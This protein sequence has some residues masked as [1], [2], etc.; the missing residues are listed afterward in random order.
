MA[1]RIG[2]KTRL[3]PYPD[4]Y[5]EAE[6]AVSTAQDEILIVSNWTLPYR[7]KPEME[8]ARKKYFAAALKKATSTRVKYLRVAQIPPESS[9]ILGAIPPLVVPHLT[10]CMKKRDAGKGDIGVFCC[11]PTVLVSFLLVDSKFLLLQLDERDPNTGYFQVSRALIVQDDE[12]KVTQ[13]FKT[14]FE[15]LIRRDSHSMQL[16]ELARVEDI[17]HRSTD[18]ATS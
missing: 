3:V 9:D 15:E 7:P 13:V 18:A 6:E 10:Q 2:A 14:I 1:P 8:E 4:A 12:K 11:N 5:Q 17:S 16:K